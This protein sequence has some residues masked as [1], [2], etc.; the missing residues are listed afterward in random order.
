MTPPDTSAALQN[1][2]DDLRAV[3]TRSLEMLA[4]KDAT[5]AAVVKERDEA[6]RRTHEIQEAESQRNA[7][8]ES[9]LA[10]CRNYMAAARGVCL[11]RVDPVTRIVTHGDSGL[12]G[13]SNFVQGIIAGLME[14]ADTASRQLAEARAERDEWKRLIQTPGQYAL[15][16]KARADKATM[17]F[18][19]ACA[20]LCDREFIRVKADYYRGHK[21]HANWIVER[22][23]GITEAAR[24]LLEVSDPK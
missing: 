12:G 9:D 21:A 20:L 19:D 2:I 5:L 15:E 24:T 3:A 4:E 1:T 6:R 13:I 22:E 14:R 10:K 18:K 8:L 23:A 11:E 17:A 16:E 7:R